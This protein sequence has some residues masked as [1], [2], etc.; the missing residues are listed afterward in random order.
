EKPAD[1]MEHII[2]TSSRPGDVVLD[3]FVTTQHLI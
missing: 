3:A 1:M 2:Q